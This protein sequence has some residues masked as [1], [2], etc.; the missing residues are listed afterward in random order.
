MQTSLRI[1][2]PQRPVQE[3]PSECTGQPI[4]DRVWMFVTQLFDKLAI[5]FWSMSLTGQTEFLHTI[6]S[7]SI[8]GKK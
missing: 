8:R 4:G 5:A 7:A 1:S 2:D 3:S 6:M